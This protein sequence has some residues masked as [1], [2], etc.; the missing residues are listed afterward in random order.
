MLMPSE[1]ANELRKVK[2]VTNKL[3]SEKKKKK[4]END[5]LRLWYRNFTG[6][7]YNS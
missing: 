1:S 6:R 3:S 2:A 5:R 7:D 4:A